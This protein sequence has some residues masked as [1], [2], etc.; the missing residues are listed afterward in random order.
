M[1]TENCQKKKEQMNPEDI[2][3]KDIVKFKTRLLDKLVKDIGVV[4]EIDE[5]AYYGEMYVK[6]IPFNLKIS[7]LLMKPSKVKKK[8]GEYSNFNFTNDERSHDFSLGYKFKLRLTDEFFRRYIEET[9]YVYWNTVEEMKKTF[10][11]VDEIE[12][13]IDRFEGPHM[14][15]VTSSIHGIRITDEFIKEFSI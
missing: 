13:M 4:E 7:S 9:G 15:N 11:G 3:I 6:V 1:N 10:N 14:Y 8:I 2:H 12:F 5:D